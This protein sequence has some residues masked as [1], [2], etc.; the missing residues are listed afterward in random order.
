MRDERLRNE[1]VDRE[2]AM[3]WWDHEMVKWDEMVR[4]LI[5]FSSSPIFFFLLGGMRPQPDPEKLTNFIK[6]AQVSFQNITS[7]I[8]FHDQI[9][10]YFIIISTISSHVSWLIISSTISQSTIS[11][12]T[13]SFSTNQNR[14]WKVRWWVIVFYISLISHL[15]MIKMVEVVREDHG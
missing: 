11:Q 9:I 14:G 10:S 5:E 3:R 4:W 12:L 13:I 1:M 2:T 15:E 6:T 8:L 7:T